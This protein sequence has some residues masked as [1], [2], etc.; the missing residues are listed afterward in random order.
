MKKKIE[1]SEGQLREIRR[2]RDNGDSQAAIAG[3]YGCSVYC[4]KVSPAER[5]LGCEELP[6][7]KI[8]GDISLRSQG[9]HG[10]TGKPNKPILSR[11]HHPTVKPLAL[12]AYLVRLVTPPGGLVLDPFMGSGSTLIAA[13]QEGFDAVGI[14]LEAE[15][16]ELAERRIRGHLGML[17]EVECP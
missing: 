12:M 11:N 7:T 4:A 14:G 13:A 16:C 3:D 15:N 6:L 10:Q 2:R 5:N 1:F 17:A 9:V 8:E